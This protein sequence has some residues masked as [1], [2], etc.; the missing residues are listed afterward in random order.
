MRLRKILRLVGAIVLATLLVFGGV[1]LNAYLKAEN[2]FI[3][4][5]GT[6]D[7]AFL[8]ATWKMSPREVE[9]ANHAVLTP[10]EDLWVAIDAPSVMDPARY[11]ELLQKDVMLWGHSS[12]ITYSFFDNKLYECYIGMTT[13][14]ADKSFSEIRA[15]LEQQFGVG[16]MDTNKNASLLVN[17]V[18]DTPKQK[19]TMW[20]GKNDGENAGYYLGIRATYKPSETEINDIIRRQRRNNNV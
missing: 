9:R 15:T 14:D 16:K 2:R 5:T 20:A 12:K 1:L 13:Y 17:L 11:K 6:G 7:K 18:W 3:Y 19:L 8:Q 4:A 10:N